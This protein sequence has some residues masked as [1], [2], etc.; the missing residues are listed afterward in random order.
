[1]TVKEIKKETDTYKCNFYV[2]GTYVSLTFKQ[3]DKNKLV[4]N[5]DA[6]GM[7]I[8]ITFHKAVKAVK[9]Q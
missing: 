9:A 2:D 1:M 8:P 3:K 4:G 6:E 7:M 5:A